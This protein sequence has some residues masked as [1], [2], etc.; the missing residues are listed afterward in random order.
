MNVQSSS[1]RV[2][3]KQTMSAERGVLASEKTLAGPSMGAS[4]RRFCARRRRRRPARGAPFLGRPEPVRLVENDFPIFGLELLVMAT[5]SRGQ[6]GECKVLRECR[7]SRF[8]VKHL[9]YLGLD[10]GRQHTTCCDFVASHGIGGKERFPRLCA[11]WHGTECVTHDLERIPQSL[12]EQRAR[13]IV[14]DRENGCVDQQVAHPGP[15]QRA[16]AMV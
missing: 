16:C 5:V 7:L 1:G 10:L 3:R 2:L 9:L 15:Q 12:G 11:D 8:G 14:P 4:P 13:Q 6:E